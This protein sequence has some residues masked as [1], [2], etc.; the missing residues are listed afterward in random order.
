MI[1][2]LT[3][4]P[5]KPLLIILSIISITCN[6]MQNKSNVFY[7]E[8]E[9]NQFGWSYIIITDNYNP[10]WN[11]KYYIFN[12]DGICFIPRKL[13]ND[14][15]K[16]KVIDSLKN[17][18]SARCKELMK[19]MDDNGRVITYKFYCVSSTQASWSDSAVQSI[20]HNLDSAIKYKRR[21]DY[22]KNKGYPL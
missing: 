11:G 5:Y 13:A 16:I 19:S 3:N 20:Q 6:T 21:L 4:K 2:L 10:T 8:L 18:M 1:K 9:A 12:S 7:I 14:S 17:D 22:L 15:T